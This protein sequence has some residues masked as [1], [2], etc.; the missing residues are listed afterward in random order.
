MSR[1]LVCTLPCEDDG[2]SVHDRC[3]TCASCCAPMIG[4]KFYRAPDGD[5]YCAGKCFPDD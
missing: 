5:V 4:R 2:D 1:C 3:E